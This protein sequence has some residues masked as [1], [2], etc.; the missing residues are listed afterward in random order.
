[1]ANSVSPPQI[2]N[3]SAVILAG[4]RGQR[5]GEQDK[6]WIPLNDNTLIEHTLQRLQLQLADISISANRNVDKYQKLGVPV[7]IDQHPDFPG[8]L[9]GIYAALSQIKSEWL[10]TVPCDTPLFPSDLLNQF[11]NALSQQPGLIAVATDQQYMQPV[12]CLI[13]SSLADKLK[14]FIDEGGHKTGQWIKQNNPVEV[15]FKDNALQFFNINSPDDLQHFQ[16]EL[17]QLQKSNN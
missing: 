1:M 15:M 9:A 2:N 3:T 16:L 13:H 10:L 7:I 4:G 8:P 14:A 17:A 6:G 12:F 5:M 11:I